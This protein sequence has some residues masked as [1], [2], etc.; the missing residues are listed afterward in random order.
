MSVLPSLFFFFKSHASLVFTG[1]VPSVRGSVQAYGSVII[2][3]RLDVGVLYQVHSGSITRNKQET[4]YT[5]AVPAL[6]SQ[7][8]YSFFDGQVE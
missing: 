3:A 7:Q 2:A 4:F 8:V 1:S 5:L 6:G